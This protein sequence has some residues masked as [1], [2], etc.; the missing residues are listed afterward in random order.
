MKNISFLVAMPRSGNTIFASIMNQNTDVAVTPNSITL[1]ITKDIFLLKETDVFQNYPDHK[2]L[3]N[4]LN[5]VFDSY[6]KD[7]PQQYIIDRGPVTT[8]GNMM[9]IK[10]HLGQPLKCVVLLRSMVDVIASFVKLYVKEN[11]KPELTMEQKISI[12]VDV[13]GGLVKSLMALQEIMKP[14]NKHMACFVHYDDLVSNPEKEIN[15]IY[16]F[17]N[18]PKFKHD[19]KNISQLK[20]NDL[21]YNDSVYVNNL[22]TLR[23]DG[24]SKENNPYYDL[25]PKRFIDKY[26]HITFKD[27]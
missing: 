26:K 14:E 11:Y 2:S 5:G 20:V 10:K 1:E 4:V 12:L 3:D 6:Y 9:L 7:W 16:K 23:T 19:F 25:I 17:L 13:N 24:V 18:I 21:S 15:K 8:T 27:I 22:H